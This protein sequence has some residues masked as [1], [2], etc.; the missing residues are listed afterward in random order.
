MFARC[1]S[2]NALSLLGHYLT[3]SKDHPLELT[4]T[5]QAYCFSYTNA[6]S[7]VRILS[8]NM[9]RFTRLELCQKPGLPDWIIQD[10]FLNDAT[11]LVEVKVHYGYLT[12]F[13]ATIS[14]IDD[15]RGCQRWRCEGS[16]TDLQPLHEAF[17]LSDYPPQ[18]SWKIF[19]TDEAAH[20]PLHYL[21]HLSI[22]AR[23]DGILSQLL[24]RLSTPALAS[25][26]LTIPDLASLV[27]FTNLI[28]RSK[29]HL[30]L[31][32]LVLNFHQRYDQNPS[33]SKLYD[34]L[35]LC[36]ALSQLRVKV[37]HP[38][39]L[40]RRRKDRETFAYRLFGADTQ[41]KGSWTWLPHWLS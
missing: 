17:T 3:N 31:N 14:P 32:N 38:A 13:V 30:S 25:S 11:E 24:S 40:P 19:L 29:C 33:E 26:E 18:S 9:S 36:P 6:V 21:R 1:G 7:A 12:Q 4:P 20:S 35:V 8:K 2:D 10:P 16:D 39:D 28:Q 27:P 23:H 22:T 5:Y 15:T 41:E 37:S 34:L